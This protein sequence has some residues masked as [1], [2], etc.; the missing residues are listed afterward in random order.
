MNIREVEKSSFSVI[1][2]EGLGKSQE[3]DIW[4]PPLWQ[5][6]TNAFDEIAHLVKQP[7]AVWGSHV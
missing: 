3:A 7:L 4:I 1:G 6:A 2:K 5:Q